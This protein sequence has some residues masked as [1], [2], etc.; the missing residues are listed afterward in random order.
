MKKYLFVLI[1]VF[2]QLFS[3]TQTVKNP[4]I[5]F[6]YFQHFAFKHFNDHYI[7]SE[8]INRDKQIIL[9]TVY[10]CNYDKND[11]IIEERYYSYNSYINFRD[12]ADGTTIYS[13][14]SIGRISKVIT[15][16]QSNYKSKYELNEVH[17]SLYQYNSF[18]SVSFIENYSG[19]RNRL[20]NVLETL[21]SVVSIILDEYT[22]QWDW[23]YTGGVK[24]E[25]DP[26]NN[27]LMRQYSVIPDNFN[28]GVNSVNNSEFT[29]TFKYDSLNR[30]IIET[31]TVHS[32]NGYPVDSNS[33]WNYELFYK[34][35]HDSL[36]ITNSKSSYP[37]LEMT[38][39]Y[40]SKG[41]AIN[42]IKKATNN[43]GEDWLTTNKFYY[44]NIGRVIKQIE[45]FNNSS[46]S[47]EFNFFY[48]KN[49]G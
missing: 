27:N 38:I 41:N 37:Y 13:Y 43:D 42:K 39:K 26:L 29:H 14:D 5:E 15:Y 47:I 8:Y 48:N 46:N 2:S 6:K 31:H 35:Y 34:Y 17:I 16:L 44:D 28:F 40:N 3:W 36:I 23:I 32:M 10:S 18:D 20:P 45:T 25:Y 7:T 49:G 4:N 1:L 24:Y 33:V 30:L 19:R 22:E 12:R 21:D 9:D 11:R